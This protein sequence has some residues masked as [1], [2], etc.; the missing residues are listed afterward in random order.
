MAARPGRSSPVPD[1]WQARLD[2]LRRLLPLPLLAVSAAAAFA[3]PASSSHAW[4]RFRVGLPLVVVAAIFWTIATVRLRGVAS[5]RWRTLVF[6]GQTTL[7]GVLVWVSPL[8]GVFA[9]TG[10]L[11]AYGLGPRWRAT[12]FALTAL[13]VSAAMVGGYPSANTGKT[14]TYLVVAVVML[15]L[16]FTTS[17]ITNRAVDQNQERGRMI[18]ELA[19]ANGRLAASM[20]ENATLH[21]QLVL[22]AREAGVVEERQRLAGEIHDTLAQGLTGII[23]QLEAAEHTRHRPSES[24]RHLDQARELARSSLTEA[25]RSVR[26]LRP[27]QLEDASLQEALGALADTWSRQSGIAAEVQATGSCVRIGADTE[28]A[29]FRVAQEALANV[30]KHARAGKVRLTLTCLGDTLLLDVVDDGIGFDTAGDTDGYGLAGMRHR[31]A[32]VAGTLT[33]D[34]A[35]GSGTTLNAAVPLLARPPDARA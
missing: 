32:R 1:P 14:L 5:T 29:V 4:A 17:T 30:G 16:V 23:A 11:F 21:T 3:V 15:T 7:A 31:L 6:A 10:F 12:G 8:Y 13:V 20:A 26:A 34:S 24:S 25:R 22:Q 28:A 35:P 33:I 18:D 9:Y 27:E 19:E 2:R